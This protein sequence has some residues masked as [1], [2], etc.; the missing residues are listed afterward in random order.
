MR[1]INFFLV[2]YESGNTHVPHPI[3][4]D[5]FSIVAEK[6]SGQVFFREKLSD[7]LTFVA[8]D[9]AWIMAQGFDAV[10]NLIMQIKDNGA[11][12]KMW[13]GKF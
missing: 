3:Y 11:L 1:E 10:V 13:Q 8:E 9:F 2:D 4:G 5:G 7:K 6:E 12:V